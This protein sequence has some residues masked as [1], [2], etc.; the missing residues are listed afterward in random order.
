MY[1]WP[2]FTRTHGRENE[3]RGQ[4]STPLRAVL[5]WSDECPSAG[6]GG[7]RG[8]LRQKAG[9]WAPGVLQSVCHT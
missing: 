7:L 2:G 3:P 4:D 1:E 5:D 6:V 9:L 8:L